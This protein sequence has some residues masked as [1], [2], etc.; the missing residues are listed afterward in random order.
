MLVTFKQ[1]LDMAE[2]GNFCIPAF[3][4]YNIET[5]MGAVKAA[6]ELNAPCI[7]QVYPRLMKEEVG[8]YLSPAVV[9]AA[10]KASVPVCFH[11]DHGPSE[12]EVTRALRWGATGIMMDG[13][14]LNFED[15][16]AI[17]KRV[18]DLCSYAGV[19]V[20]GE[21][22]HIGTVNDDSMDEFTTPD[23]AKAFVER[24]GVQALAVLVGNAHGRY[25]KPPKIDIQRIADIRK[26]T[27]GTALVLHGGSGIP[28]EAI[29]EAVKAGIRKL[30]VA[31][32]ICYAFRDCVQEEIVKPD[33]TVAVD[34]FMKKP[35]EAV[36]EFCMTKV[37]LC[38]AE[39]K[40]K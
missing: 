20:E 23:D 15:N 10:H 12:L 16:I 3:N 40:A 25:K 30:N 11:L 14:A 6:E 36:K 32:D 38:G 1:V 39:G 22:G 33:R 26:A 8:Y 24:T 17:T 5:C 37:L 7:L 34:N 27:N 29:K 19:Q 31:T 4:V 28:D 18:V 13:S 21:L 2:A 9:A 35:I